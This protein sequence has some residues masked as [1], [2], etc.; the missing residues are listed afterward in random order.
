MKTARTIPIVLLILSLFFLSA[1]GSSND[2]AEVYP[3]MI[4]AY[5][6]AKG[7]ELTY[8]CSMKISDGTRTAEYNLNGEL[9]IQKDEEQV[10]MAQRGDI[11]ID[12]AVGSTATV[13]VK[14]YYHNG[15]LY[16][17]IND[18]R[19]RKAMSLEDAMAMMGPI[20]TPVVNLDVSDFKE[21]TL[22][23]NEDGTRTVSVMIS[24]DAIQK[25][26]GL[27]ESWRRIA[28]IGENEGTVEIRDVRGF[29]IIKDKAP[30]KES[31]TIIGTIKTGEKTLSVTE[32]LVLGIALNEAVAVAQPSIYQFTVLN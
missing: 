3:E 2:P 29:F 11:R 7:R 6:E 32:E 12:L 22:K 17:E 4:R 30:V 26:V 15:S 10:N 21:L 31:L 25:I 28:S 19:Y 20:C 27:E 8:D 9:Q 18:S 13:P 16:S 5:N 1:C 23:E 24:A 14:A